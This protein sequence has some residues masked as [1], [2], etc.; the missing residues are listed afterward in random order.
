M[1]MNATGWALAAVLILA[2]AVAFAQG[3][4][5][6]GGGGS[7][8]RGRSGSVRLVI[9][10]WRHGHVRRWQGRL[11]ERYRPRDGKP[12][13][14]DLFLNADARHDGLAKPVAIGRQR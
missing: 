14:P 12:G 9:G 13:G 5:A 11:P 1:R 7:G 8:W 6:G 4:G 3:G 10:A 2:P